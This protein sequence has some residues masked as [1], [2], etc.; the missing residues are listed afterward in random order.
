MNFF[1]KWLC[2]LYNFCI[3]CV[4]VFVFLYILVYIF[5]ELFLSVVIY[6][7][8]RYYFDVIILVLSVSLLV[9]WVNIYVSSDSSVVE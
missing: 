4:L 6:N 3:S 2:I 1:F 5:G 9:F 8:G 7:L